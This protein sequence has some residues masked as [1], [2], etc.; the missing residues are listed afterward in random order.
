[1]LHFIKCVLPVV[2][3]KCLLQLSWIVRSADYYTVLPYSCCYSMHTDTVSRRFCF[4][5]NKQINIR[6]V[7]VW[8]FLSIYRSFYFL[9]IYLFFIIIFI[10]PILSFTFNW[11]FWKWINHDNC[12][13]SETSD[14]AFIVIWTFNFFSHK[15]FRWLSRW[16]V[17]IKEKKLLA[18]MFEFMSKFRFGFLYLYRTQSDVLFIFSQSLLQSVLAIATVYPTFP[19][20]KSMGI[21]AY[22]QTFFF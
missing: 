18:K 2:W 4:R 7:L 10:M 22:I 11:S 19:S 8:L 16:D 20:L 9:S 13:V 1:M 15:D 3:M 12:G 21:V 14:Y 5:Y 17:C 6:S